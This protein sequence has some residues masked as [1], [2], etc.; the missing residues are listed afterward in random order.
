MRRL[1]LIVL[2]ALI[3]TSCTKE[4]PENEKGIIKSPDDKSVVATIENFLVAYNSN[5]I[6]K[7]LKYF[8]AD[9]RGITSRTNDVI[10]I[11]AL[12]GNLIAYQKQFPQSAWSTKIE[13]INVSGKVAFVISQES[14]IA[15]GTNSVNKKPVYN[16]YVIRI[17]KKQKNDGWKINRSVLTSIEE[18]KEPNL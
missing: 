3:A 17:L 1:I 6:K 11:N 10:G 16:M 4:V 8:D 18:V 15:P 12:R 13:E 7:A 5:D 9:Y 14:F 2:L